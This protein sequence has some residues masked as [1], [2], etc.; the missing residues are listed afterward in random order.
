MPLARG[1]MQGVLGVAKARELPD[2]ARRTFRP[3]AASSHAQK[4]TDGK[5]TPGKVAI[6]STCYVNY[7]EP[8]IGHDLLAILEHNAIPYVLV[9]K[10]ACCGM[11]KLELGDLETV[12]KHK[13]INIP[14]LAKLAR[15]GYAILTPVPSCTLMFK[16]EL[17]LM[18]PDDADVKAVQDAMFDPFEYLVLRQQGRPAEDRL[19]GCIGQG[20]VPHP[21]PL[22]GAEHRPEDARNAGVDPRHRGEHRRALRRPRRHLG[23]EDRVLRE[24]DEDR[25]SGV[26][27]DGAKRSRTGSARTARLR[28]ATSCRACARAKTPKLRTRRAARTRSRCCAPPTASSGGLR[29]TR[30]VYSALQPA[31]HSEETI[32]MTQKPRW[33]AGTGFRGVLRIFVAVV[34][35]AF[36]APVAQAACA[37]APGPG[38]DWS[39]CQKA[40]LILRDANLSNGRLART[41]FGRSDLSGAKLVA[42]DLER[43]SLDNAR[44]VGADLSRAKLVKVNAYRAN[45]DPRSWSAPI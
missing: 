27:P 1:V 45:L 3:S 44:L 6:F 13:D 12:A 9:E 4:V 8:G 14:P 30:F 2:Y 39:K 34:S 15:E 20:V 21:L 23:R 29:Y 38:V 19:Q 33:D 16:Q 26:P 11:P 17:P 41:D 22:A 32:L 37:D 10:E 42:A 36:A 24:L 7:N 40:R 5:N 35:V 18:F 25:S 28:A 31:N 43:A